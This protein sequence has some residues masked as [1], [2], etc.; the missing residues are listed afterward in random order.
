MRSGFRLLAALL[1][2]LAARIAPAIAQPLPPDPFLWLEQVNSPRAMKWVRAQNAA[3]LQRLTADPRYAGFL[4]T[5]LALDQ[6]DNRIPLP[7]TL[8]GE[9]YNFWQDASH[10]QGIWRRTTPEDYATPHPHWETVLDLDA[11]SRAEHHHWVWKGVTCWQPQDQRCL[12]SLSDGGEDAV[13][14]REFD[15]GTRRFVPGGFS[16]PRS[17]MV[18]DWLDADTILVGTDWGPGS[19][20][21]SGY[22]FV[23]KRLRRGQSLAQAQ[24]YFRGAPS[25]VGLE[26][27]AMIDGA[28]RHAFLIQREVDFFHSEFLLAGTAGPAALDLPEKATLYGLVAGQL[29]VGLNQDVAQN[30]G[31]LKAGAI[32]A[33]DLDRPQS[34]LRAL[35]TPNSR[36]SVQEAGTTKDR[37]VAIIEDNVRGRAMTFDP[38][39]QGAAPATLDL[40]DD[41]ALSLIDTNPDN[42]TIY[43]T[44]TGFLDPTT[45]DRA[46]VAANRV[47]Q[48]VKAL[49][50]EF[51]ASTDVVEQH[52]ATSTDGTRIP[53]FIVHPKTM[54]YDGANP[55]LLYAYGGFQVSMVPTYSPIL[56][57]LWLERGGVY[58]L[59]NIRGGGEFGPA[60]HEAGLKTR[61]QTVFDDF[62]SVAE[63]L[64]ARHVTD[65]RHL[66]IRGGSNGGL[67]MGVEF[68]QHP[69]LFRAVIIEV[70]LLDMLRY[71]KIA[72]GAS[73]VGE[74]GTVDDPVQ[75]AFL[76][77]ISPYNNLHPDVRY[78]VPFIFTTTKD[79][80]VGPQHARKF[81]AKMAAM[82]LPYYYYES[83]E[84]G[85]AAGANLREAAQE[86]ALEFTYLAEKLH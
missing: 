4:R 25:D 74:Y 39:A 32:A 24:P 12:I 21:S 79:D 81:A 51:D 69:D 58:V 71:E 28:G 18:A 45:L 23:L 11:L 5:A 42:D 49:P 20:T 26:V 37:V 41:R 66:G 13:V 84:G 86:Q 15:T 46:D 52:E 55:T 33:L 57:R 29:I 85:H 50:A 22:P 1:A 43:L 59:A 77:R 67:L 40:P 82:H 70:P 73:W 16:L 65:P 53:Y 19:M 68:T 35:F 2:L 61:R 78:P 36:Q 56:G 54:K 75:R 47:P 48:P 27:V 63:D 62:S 34:G 3:T 83:I 8:H 14:T 64:I 7:V 17:K 30:G 60:W 6:N 10:V 9:I 31:T 72:A 76:A 80:R 38:T 44:V